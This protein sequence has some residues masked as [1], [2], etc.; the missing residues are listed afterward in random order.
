[1]AD[2]IDKQLRDAAAALLTGLATTGSRVYASRVYP[3][4]DT[5]LPGLRVFVDDSDI[6][7]NVMGGASRRIDRRTQLKIE[8]CGKAV[9]SYD[10]EADASKKEIETAIAGSGEF[11][12]LC[13]WVALRRIE[14]E[15]DDGAEQIVI[16]TRLIYECFTQTAANAPDI[17]L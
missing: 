7:H 15:R 2:H 16:V 14:T 6:E 4:Q 9:S 3:M 5:D 1:M 8:F 13:K 10:D 12:G 11:S 17:A